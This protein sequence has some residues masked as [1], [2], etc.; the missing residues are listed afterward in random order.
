MLPNKGKGFVSWFFKEYLTVHKR[1]KLLAS[2]CSGITL[3]MLKSCLSSTEPCCLLL[4]VSTVQVILYR[5]YREGFYKC[6][7]W[8][9]TISLT[10]KITRNAILSLH[11]GSVEAQT[12]G[13][14]PAV[15]IQELTKC[16]H[17][18]SSL[19]SLTVATFRAWFDICMN[20][21]SPV[22]SAIIPRASRKHIF[23]L[24]VVVYYI[25]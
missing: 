13:L 19:R 2:I 12:L 10:Q 6:G 21:F 25:F 16:H 7:S 1:L 17:A 14:V 3:C 9:S 11:P 4:N 15:C 8:T 22:T 5:S 18:L 23:W 24:S 20:Q